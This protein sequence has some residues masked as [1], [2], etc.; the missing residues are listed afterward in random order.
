MNYYISNA[1]GGPGSNANAGTS[2]DAP[3]RDFTPLHQRSLAPGDRVLLARGSCWNQQ[4][5]INDS[6]AK[7]AWCELGAYGSG[8]RPKI[9]RNGDAYE[10]GIRLNNLSYWRIHDLEVGRAGVGILAYYNTPG[11]EGLR[12][13]D[14]FVHDCYGVH[15]GWFPAE[16]AARMQAKKDRVD[17]SSGIFI[18]CEPMELAAGAYVLRDIVLDRI[19]GTYNADSVAIQPSAKREEGQIDYPMRDIILNHLYLHDDVAPNPGGIPDTL[20]VINCEHVLIENSYFDNECGRHT[21]SGTA[22]VLMVGVK[23]LHYI[24]SSFTRTPDTGSHDQCAIDFESTNRNVK[25]RGCYFGQNAGPG[26]EFL[27]IWGEKAFSLDHEVSGNAFEGNGWSTHGGQAGSGGIHHYGGN[28]ATAVIR[29][30]LVYEPGRP[31]YHGEFINFTLINNLVASQPLYNALHGYSGVQGQNGWFYQIR[32]AQGG[33]SNIAEFN[34]EQRAWIAD[35][36]EAAAWIS[37]AET[38]TLQPAVVAARA[39]QA[40]RAGKVAVRGRAFKAQT[41]GAQAAVRITLND[42]VIWEAQ[43]VSTGSWD[44]AETNLDNLAVEKG[45]TLRF[46]VQGAANGLSD[47]VSWAP[48]IAY[49]G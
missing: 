7:D 30:N 26:V 5:V 1:P 15:V 11:H 2:E 35:G 39:W 46:E 19:E 45:D 31:L 47:A 13:E 14:I 25:V 20:R 12:F 38:C 32:T 40:E 43:A 36:A 21:N 24:N 33:W 42:R 29:D 41:S 27:D 49:I 16:G 18:S 8:P 3:W 37:M 44:G 22:I 48:T 4:L 6:G 17:L 28:F 34:A 10:R 23:D 9:I